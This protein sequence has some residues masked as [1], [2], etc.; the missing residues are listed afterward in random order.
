MVT[1]PLRSTLTSGPMTS[2]ST[3][4][5]VYLKV[6]TLEIVVYLVFLSRSFLRSP[7]KD[8]SM[9]LLCLVER[10]AILVPGQMY[11]SSI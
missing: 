7:R 3:P 8:G 11:D 10:L 1:V 6:L 9:Y 5:L 4:S 2:I